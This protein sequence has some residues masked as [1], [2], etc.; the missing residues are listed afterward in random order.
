M[1]TTSPSSTPAP[2][3]VLLVDDSTEGRKA[4][5][6]VLSLRGFSVISVADGASAVEALKV[7]PPPD[8]VL[9]DLLLP[10]MDG[11]EVIR[12]SN[13]LVPRPRS[14]LITGWSF[15]ADLS[16]LGETG[17]DKVFY[18]P[19]SVTDLLDWLRTTASEAPAP[20]KP[21]VT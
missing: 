13:A 4:L 2:F 6:R 21:S 1:P 17:I 5:A 11:L 14:V 15:E 9:V 8:I 20:D 12:A 10:D 7:P 16:R 18:K 19:V 3:R